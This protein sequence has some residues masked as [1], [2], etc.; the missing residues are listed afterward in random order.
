MLA[1]QMSLL[2]ISALLEANHGPTVYD[3]LFSH[4][5]AERHTENDFEVI[6]SRISGEI[7]KDN[8]YRKLTLPATIDSKKSWAYKRIFSDTSASEED[9]LNNSACMPK[10]VGSRKKRSEGSSG[11]TTST[12]TAEVAAAN[13]AAMVG[14]KNNL[15]KKGN[16]RNI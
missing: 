4:A 12:I 5:D 7:T 16:Q 15:G 11:A 9:V 13:A 10:A 2:E 6:V 8:P 14:K 1:Q 3:S